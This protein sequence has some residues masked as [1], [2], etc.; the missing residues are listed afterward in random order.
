MEWNFNID[1][2]YKGVFIE[3]IIETKKGNKTIKKFK[4][5][6]IWAAGSCGVVTKSN[7]LPKEERWNCFTKDVP[8]IAWQKFETPEHPDKEA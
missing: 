4:A 2:V 7:W 3:R 6:Y 5:N 8:P 1:E